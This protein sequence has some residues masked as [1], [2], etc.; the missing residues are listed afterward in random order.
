MAVRGNSPPPRAPGLVLAQ[1]VPYSPDAGAAIASATAGV[2]AGSSANSSRS[3]GGVPHLQLYMEA[4][5]GAWQGAM[6][7]VVG[8]SPGSC[9][10]VRPDGHVAWRH[11]GLPDGGV[12][13]ETPSFNAGLH[14]AMQKP[15]S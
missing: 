7:P 9:L 8:S 1:V 13:G 4:S 6:G 15:T 10:V 11:V 2:H 3:G 12:A 14:F 5:P